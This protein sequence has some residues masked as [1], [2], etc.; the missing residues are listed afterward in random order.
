LPTFTD[1]F[2]LNLNLPAAAH[3][4]FVLTEEPE[5]EPG[6]RELT[7]DPAFRRRYRAAHVEFLSVA[8]R[9]QLDATVAAAFSM[10]P[11]ALVLL[12][13]DLGDDPEGIEV[14]RR[15][16]YA[17]AGKRLGAL[18]TLPEGGHRLL[19]ARRL[20]G[21]VVP[22][23]NAASAAELWDALRGV[24]SH[25]FAREPARRT[26]LSHEMT[27]RRLT[28]YADVLEYLKLR[29]H[30]L[31]REHRL[32]AENTTGIDLSPHD[33]CSLMYGAFV[34]TEAGERLVGGIRTIT[35]HL[36]SEQALLTGRIARESG[37]RHLL[38]IELH[39]PTHFPTVESFLADPAL[40]EAEKRVFRERAGRS[41]TLELSR[42]VVHPDFKGRQLMRRLV[43]VAI[44][45]SIDRGFR[46]M[47]GSCAPVLTPMWEKFGWSVYQ[48]GAER[49]VLIEQ[50]EVAFVSHV[51][52]CDLQR[53]PGEMA[54]AVEAVGLALKSGGQVVFAPPTADVAREGAPEKACGSRPFRT[55]T[56]LPL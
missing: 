39:R 30:V 8:H 27:L 4:C 21:G 22:L 7:A 51:L 49:P 6:L 41:G 20:L 53:L 50:K 5:S 54:R 24:V 35:P 44:A 43:E 36:V 34:G 15:Q 42:G 19:R 38:E 56:P 37:S 26:P 1:E 17:H 55:S 14:L 3:F 28:D 33:K 46:F 29:G 48:D 40:A 12:V 2:A 16:W 18:V 31:G 47:T 11:A 32:A 9:D 10:D 25:L 23:R 52:F 13:L 45:D